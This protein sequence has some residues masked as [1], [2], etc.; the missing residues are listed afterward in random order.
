M[1]LKTISVSLW[2]NFIKSPDLQNPT[3]QRSKLKLSDVSVRKQALSRHTPTGNLRSTLRKGCDAKMQ[4][5]LM[6]NPQELSTARSLCHP[7]VVAWTCFQ[8]WKPPSSPSYTGTEVPG[9]ETKNAQPSRG[10]PEESTPWTHSPPLSSSTAT[11]MGQVLEARKQATRCCS[12]RP[13]SQGTKLGEVGGKRI[14]RGK[15][16]LSSTRGLIKS[17]N[18]S[19]GMLDGKQAFHGFLGYYKAH[20]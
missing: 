2:K 16:R 11:S 18:L 9:R 3:V 19:E 4:E 1:L 15:Q 17:F 13:G 6:W 14:W 8:L 20:Q 12:Y 5:E 7:W 10:Q